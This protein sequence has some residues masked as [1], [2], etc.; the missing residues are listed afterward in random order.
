M[1]PRKGTSEPVLVPSQLLMEYTYIGPFSVGSS[2]IESS[3]FAGNW[4]ELNS[5]WIRHNYKLRINSPVYSHKPTLISQS[6]PSL[7]QKSLV[8]WV[9]LPN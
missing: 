2:P 5:V 6:S 7:R 9:D 3:F 4:V 1:S 8:D